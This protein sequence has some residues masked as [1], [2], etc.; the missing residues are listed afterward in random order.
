ME[1]LIDF[2]GVKV[3]TDYPVNYRLVVHKVLLGYGRPGTSKGVHS[4][5]AGL[6]DYYSSPN[7]VW[8]LGGHGGWSTARALRGAKSGSNASA[9]ARNTAC[10]TTHAYIQPTVLVAPGNGVR[11]FGLRVGPAYYRRLDQLLAD[12]LGGP[13]RTTQFA[14]R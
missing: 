9:R 6:G 3:Q 14:G 5:E 11:G 12:T 10:V 7:G 8:R 13:I 2:N 4:A 1:T